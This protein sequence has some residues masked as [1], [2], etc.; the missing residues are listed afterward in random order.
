[1][2]MP[3]IS[4]QAAEI[5]LLEEITA[6]LGFALYS[7]KKDREKQKV[8]AELKN[9]QQFQEKILTSLAEGIVVEDSGGHITYVNPALE[10]MLGYKRGQLLG[11]HWRVLIPGD[12]LEAVEERSRRRKSKFASDTKPD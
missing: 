7:L 4:Y 6:D 3:K 5:K 12:Q 1:L 10:Q 2:V 11:K 9:L 8:E